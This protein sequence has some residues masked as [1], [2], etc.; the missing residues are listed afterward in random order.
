MTWTISFKPTALNLKNLERSLKLTLFILLLS[1]SK[2]SLWRKFQARLNLWGMEKSLEKALTDQKEPRIRLT[3]EWLQEIIS[4]LRC[5]TPSCLASLLKKK[6]SWMASLWLEHNSD[7]K[8]EN[9]RCRN[10]TKPRTDGKVNLNLTLK[11]SNRWSQ[12]WELLPEPQLKTSSF[13]YLVS[14][15]SEAW[16]QCL[17][18]HKLT[19]LLSK[20]QMSV[21]AWALGAKT[22]KTV[23]IL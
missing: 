11:S 18:K 3:S 23:L 6:L 8:L 16:W 4:T 10:G 15:T 19:K 1:G 20:Q 21:C 5:I 12:D 17:E 22:P 13:W 2:I 9:T 7:K 14:S